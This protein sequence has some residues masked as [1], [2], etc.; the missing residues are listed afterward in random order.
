MANITSLINQLNKEAPPLTL[1]DMISKPFN[2]LVYATCDGLPIRDVDKFKNQTLKDT[3]IQYQA[4]HYAK[5]YGLNLLDFPSAT[6]LITHCENNHGL[7]WKPFPF[8]TIKEE[9]AKGTWFDF[10]PK[11]LEVITSKP[12]RNDLYMLE[13]AIRSSKSVALKAF[14]CSQLMSGTHGKQALVSAFSYTTAKQIC[15]A[16]NTDGIN[17]FIP[18]GNEVSSGGETTKF[19]FKGLIPENGSYHDVNILI[20]G[21]SNRKSSSRILGVSLD[22]AYLEEIDKLDHEFIETVLGRSIAS[23]NRLNLFA[24]N[25]LSPSSRILPILKRFSKNEDTE[26][27]NDSFKYW[28]FQLEDN[29]IMDKNQI[30]AIKEEYASDKYKYDREI[31][32]LRMAPVGVVL[33]QFDH[34]HIINLDMMPK[35]PNNI[36]LLHT[37]DIGGNDAS[38]LLSGM[39]YFNSDTKRMEMIVISSFYHK[40]EKASNVSTVDSSPK[41]NQDYAN[42][43]LDAVV[44]AE[45]FVKEHYPKRFF[46]RIEDDYILIDP[47]NK[48]FRTDME[49]V[50]KARGMNHLTIA[51]ADNNSTDA[52]KANHLG[53]QAN[54][55]VSGAGAGVEAGFSFANT[56]LSKDRV[57]VLMDSHTVS[58]YPAYDYDNQHLIDEIRE[59]RRKPNGDIVLKDENGLFHGDSVQC[60]RYLNNA[61]YK[62]YSLED[63]F[64][65]EL[66][67]RYAQI[68]VKNDIEQGSNKANETP[69]TTK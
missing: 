9:T 27:S 42:L 25:P 26:H 19:V 59:Y 13:G 60:F 3:V 29:P 4:W 6:A 66:V 33:H 55:G 34:R 41:S 67:E 31:R 7:D 56:C 48:L 39:C 44:F 63:V 23:P 65:K 58:Q 8:P 64:Q 61:F 68:T 49:Q 18:W 10:S 37:V 17:A 50:A 2:S 30:E 38:V 36:R 21:A 54:I 15:F 35:Q 32:G 1:G 62:N 22:C 53:G 46:Y 43:M 20:A 69:V 57:A 51:K 52:R 24:C 47:A 28:K 16:K 11:Q 40:S 45:Q 5:Q 14:F 12:E